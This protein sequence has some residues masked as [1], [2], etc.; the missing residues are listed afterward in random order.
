MPDPIGWGDDRKSMPPH[1]QDSYYRDLGVRSFDGGPGMVDLSQAN[2]CMALSNGMISLMDRDIGRILDHLKTIG[3][4]ENTIVA[5]VSDHGE[6]MGDHGLM[7]KGPFHYEGLIRIPLIMQWPGTIDAGVTTRSP[8]S[9]LDF[10][11]TV[12]ELADIKYPGSNPTDWPGPYGTEYAN[13]NGGIYRHAQRLPGRSLVPIL[14]GEAERVHDVV[15]VE[16]DED[17]RQLMIRTAVSERYKISAY[18]NETYGHLFDLQEDPE[19]RDNLWDNPECRGI[20]QD[21]LIKLM[22]EIV[23]T[24]NRLNRRQSSA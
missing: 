12:L 18:I 21:L 16:E 19:E 2:E 6:L 7:A 1:F 3:R 17:V 4:Y 5:F 8:V 24:E 15:L 13:K 10:M 20:K 9:L 22:E 14:V 11:P 23:R